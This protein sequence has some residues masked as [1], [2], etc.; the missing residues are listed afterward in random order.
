M[1]TPLSWQTASA[2]D[3]LDNLAVDGLAWEYLRR[4]TQYQQDFT[5]F[6]GKGGYVWE[7]TE[8]IRDHWGLRCPGQ[9]CLHR[10]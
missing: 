9:P 7:M 6:R 4:N 2:Y 5:D 10:A 8:I 1:L 3:Y